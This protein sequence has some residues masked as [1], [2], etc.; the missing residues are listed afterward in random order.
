[1]HKVRVNRPTYHY[2]AP[3]NGVLVKLNDIIISKK[4]LQTLT[5]ALITF[6][7]AIAIHEQILRKLYQLSEHS[8]IGTKERT[9]KK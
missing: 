3:I 4:H 1:M 8:F 7:K 2:T 9:R 5:F 6:I